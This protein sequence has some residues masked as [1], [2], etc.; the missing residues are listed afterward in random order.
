MFCDYMCCSI[1]I[2]GSAACNLC[3]VARGA[4][5]GYFQF[6]IHVWDIAAGILIVTEAGGV[7]R[8][9]RGNNKYM[10]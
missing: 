8:D 1:R 4:A 5:E 3:A 7:V 6:G 10:L 9:P 2:G